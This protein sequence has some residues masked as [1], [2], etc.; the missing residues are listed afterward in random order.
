MRQILSKTCGNRNIGG[1]S[2]SENQIELLELAAL[3]SD[4]QSSRQP[5]HPD[6]NYR[7]KPLRR[8]HLRRLTRRPRIHGSNSIHPTNE[9]VRSAQILPR[10]LRT[11]RPKPSKTKCQSL[12]K[13]GDGSIFDSRLLHCAPKTSS[14]TRRI[15][16]YITYGPKNAENPNRGFSTI[17]EEFR[18]RYTLETMCK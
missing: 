7:Q 13:T 3:V 5:V 10:K 18:G 9:H 2:S 16:F 15:L 1:T 11:R 6:T 14:E 17:R 12:L 4:P 8:D